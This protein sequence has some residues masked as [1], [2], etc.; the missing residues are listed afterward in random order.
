MALLL[1]A[2][3]HFIPDADKPEGIVEKLRKPQTMGTRRPQGKGNSYGGYVVFPLP[4]REPPRGAH[5][6]EASARSAE[7]GG[8]KRR[9][10][11]RKW[12]PEPP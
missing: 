4:H 5:D 9:R 1:V 8:R 7:D 3:L 11:A 10:K 2:V 12:H 6:Y